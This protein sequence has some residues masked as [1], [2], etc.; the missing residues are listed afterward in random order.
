MEPGIFPATLATLELNQIEL[1]NPDAPTVEDMDTRRDKRRKLVTPAIQRMQ[2]FPSCI[3]RPRT[4]QG[5]ILGEE[6]RELSR[7]AASSH[8]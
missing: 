8:D 3:M 6:S 1:L 5:S 7:G 4:T 2:D